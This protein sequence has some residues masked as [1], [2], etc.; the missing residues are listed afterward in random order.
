MARSS[1]EAEYCAMA[2]TIFELTWLKQLLKE[3]QIGENKQMTLVCDNQGALH[4]AS[5]LVFL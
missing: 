3:L 5:N 4:I 1:A 2:S